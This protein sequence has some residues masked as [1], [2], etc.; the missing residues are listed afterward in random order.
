MPADESPVAATPV[1]AVVVTTVDTAEQGDAPAAEE[2]Y[3]EEADIVVTVAAPTT[4]GT[5][6]PTSTSLA[7]GMHCL[8]RCNHWSHKPKRE[9]FRTLCPG[10]DQTRLR[11]HLTGLLCEVNGISQPVRLLY[12]CPASRMVWMD[13]TSWV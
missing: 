13:P 11:T 5:Q 7:D 1:E 12:H 4:A 3:V 2:P 8:R 6:L 10:V 9:A